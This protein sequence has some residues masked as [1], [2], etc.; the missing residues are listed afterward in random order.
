M[1]GK[2]AGVGVARYELPIPKGGHAVMD[3]FTIPPKNPLFERWAQLKINEIIQVINS[4]G[5]GGSSG[6]VVF[7]GLNSSNLSTSLSYIGG[8]DSSSL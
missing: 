2:R 7:G 5:G 6:T 8:L 1:L 4:G 3:E